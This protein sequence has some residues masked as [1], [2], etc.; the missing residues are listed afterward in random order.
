MARKFT[1][2]YKDDPIAEE[3]A[4]GI[5]GTDVYQGSQYNLS[6]VPEFEGI[7]TAATD[8]NRIQDLYNLYMGGGFDQS[9]PIQ[10]SDVSIPLPGGGGSG[11]GGEVSAT[12]PDTMLTDFE[13]N[14][15]DQGVGVQGAPGDPIVAPGEMPVTQ[16][17]MDAF[18]QIPVTPAGGQPIDPTGMLPQIPEVVAQDPTT[19]IPQL[20][21]ETPSY[22]GGERTLEDAGA[23][24]DDM[25]S[26][27]YQG[28]QP[29]DTS[30]I[31]QNIGEGI[32]EDDIESIPITIDA[33]PKIMDTPGVTTVE[34]FSELDDLEADPGAQPIEGLDTGPSL[35]DI[36]KDKINEIGQSIAALPG[37]VYDAVSQTVDIAGKK[38]NLGTAAAKAIL[39]KVVGGPISLVIDALNA[40]NLPGGPTA[41]TSKAQSIG[42]AGEGQY[43]DKYGINTQS[44]FG[45]YDQYNID[46][47]EE[48]ETALE[49][50]KN[51]YDTEQEYLDMTTRMRQELEDR[52]EYNKISGVG[53]DIDDDPTGDAQ[54]AEETIGTP[55][56][57]T[58][59]RQK[60][61]EYIQEIKQQ[62]A[63]DTNTQSGRNEADRQ[64]KNTGV[65]KVD[66]DQGTRYE[67]KSG[68]K[69]ASAEEAAEKGDGGGGGG[70]KKIVC[71][72]MNESYGFGSFRNKIWLKHSKSLAPE[73]QKGYHKIF[74]P[75]G[76]LS[77]TNKL[78]KKTQEHIAVHRTI[79]I[80]Q[81]ARGKV[82]LLGR[83]YRKI[84]EPICYVV[85]KY[86]KR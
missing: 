53:G 77:K 85:G 29:Q 52:K 81:E 48:L 32:T 44:Q 9:I 78:L 30:I 45:D 1:S 21:S 65:A 24:I 49:K 14:L 72:M 34:P 5:Q 84:L 59:A 62:K 75:L 57:I 83:I 50:A 4:A 66:T 86:A 71:T 80:R 69:Y 54:I 19:M 41:Q 40:A 15:I 26:T 33:A 73:Y 11:G 17:E 60:Q 64:Q 46:R 22:V 6:D 31:M 76:R 56:E 2:L 7:K 16:E 38:I 47:V 58:E 35:I 63:V 67:T 20:G 12:T 70:N 74:L 51:K 27:D 25:Y 55:P 8:Y 68:D 43:Q 18:N 28:E 3:L 82:H 39:N 61:G 10:A 13:Q 23:G 79:D 42:L 37:N 36:G